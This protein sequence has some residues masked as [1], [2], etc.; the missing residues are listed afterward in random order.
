MEQGGAHKVGIITAEESIRGYIVQGPIT[1]DLDPDSKYPETYRDELIVHV[2][3]AL[4]IM[5]V[6]RP[7]NMTKM[8]W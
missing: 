6:H 8:L 4:V 2:L 7:A 1:F 5:P 3:L